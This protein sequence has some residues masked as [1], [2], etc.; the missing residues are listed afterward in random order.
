[1]RRKIGDF[2]NVGSGIP[3]F[4]MHSY[5]EAPRPWRPGVPDGEE[6]NGNAMMCG[7][8]RPAADRR[9]GADHYRMDFQPHVGEVPEPLSPYA[10]ND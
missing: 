5:L 3:I 4:G 7:A 10:T 6:G 1:M 2:P 8:D 9:E